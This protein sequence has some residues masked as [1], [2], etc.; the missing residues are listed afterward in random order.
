MPLLDLD[1]FQRFCKET[2]NMVPTLFILLYVSLSKTNKA[3]IK[4]TED[5]YS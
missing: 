3:K 4:H 2:F 1:E 5:L